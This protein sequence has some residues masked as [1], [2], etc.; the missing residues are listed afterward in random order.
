MHRD[1]VS[2]GALCFFSQGL[3]LVYITYLFY[4]IPHYRKYEVSLT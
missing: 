3:L 4:N 2:E 1:I